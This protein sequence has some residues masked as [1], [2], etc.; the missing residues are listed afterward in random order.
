MLVEYIPDKD[1]LYHR[2]HKA[3]WLDQI[4]SHKNKNGKEFPPGLFRYR[5]DDDNLS[6]D[7]RKYSTP[8]DTKNRAPDPSTNGVVEFDAGSVRKDS[9]TVKHDPIDDNQAHSCI[10][11]NES[12][13]RKTLSNIAKWVD[14]Y[15]LQACEVSDQP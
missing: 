1:L 5:G 9:L 4:N 14:G 6:V 15:A 13:V 2:I 11:G 12:Q 3:F 7:W 10:C 8:K